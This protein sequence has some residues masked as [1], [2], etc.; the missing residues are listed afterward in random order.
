M[1]HNIPTY[2]EKRAIKKV[3]P[4]TTDHQKASI[5]T[6]GQKVIGP[7][8]S[9]LIQ[10]DLATSNELVTYDDPDSVNSFINI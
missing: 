2:T 9:K 5:N 10:P 3:A 4:Q 6:N 1:D 7:S 8:P